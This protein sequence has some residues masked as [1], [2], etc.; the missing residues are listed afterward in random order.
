M[1]SGAASPP[2]GGTIALSGPA[3]C[4][5][6]AGGGQRRWES[7]SSPSIRGPSLQGPPSPPGAPARPSACLPAAASMRGASR[8]SH[9]PGVRGARPAPPAVPA[10]GARTPARGPP[11][12]PGR[13]RL[14]GW[15]GAAGGAA[16]VR[17]GW[18][19]RPGARECGSGGQRAAAGLSPRSP[20]AA[21]R[22]GG[23]QLAGGGA[24]ED[25]QPA[26]AGG[27]RGGAR[28]QPAARAGLREE[29]E[30]DR[31]GPTQHPT[32]SPPY[33]STQSPHTRRRRI[34][35]RGASAAHRAFPHA[36]GRTL[37]EGAGSAEGP[38]ACF[39]VLP[40]HVSGL[41]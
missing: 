41:K 7:K 31:K 19:G 21:P 18:A 33:P 37:A 32:P 2:A 39:S 22:H 15:S 4:P 1:R 17:R 8:G 23:E 35:R 27:R 13:P 12:L 25:P 34:A 28:G 30:G 40:F 26:G 14:P 24:Q 10:S 36:P 3:R 9:I 11:A 16:V 5:G 20:P 29:A 38:W 6:L